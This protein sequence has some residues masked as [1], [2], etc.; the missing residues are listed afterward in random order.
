VTIRGDAKL[1]ETLS[2]GSKKK[3]TK[4]KQVG[5]GALKEREKRIKIFSYLQKINTSGKT[6]AGGDRVYKG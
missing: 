2:R 5:R 4:K 1:R 6:K 3:K